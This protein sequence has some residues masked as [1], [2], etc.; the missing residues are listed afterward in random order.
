MKGK[1]TAVFCAAAAALLCVGFFVGYLTG[2]DVLSGDADGNSDR[3]SG[4]SGQM[5]YA[6]ILEKK[7]SS[8]QVDGL[9]CNDIN[10]RGEFYF[11][12][13]EGTEITWRGTEI[14]KDDLDVGDNI[15]ITFTGDILETYPAKIE[16]VVRIQL[17]DDEM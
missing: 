4:N 8:L 13:N 15:A 7:G 3:T 6:E 11:H 9:E 14:R 12:I 1:R 16:N 17:L 10:Y 2:K 5:F